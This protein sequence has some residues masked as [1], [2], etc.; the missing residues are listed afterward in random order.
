MILLVDDD[1]GFLDTAKKALKNHYKD[2]L[3]AGNAT[4]ALGL[5]KAIS[6]S[7]ALVDLDLPDCNGFDLISQIREARP[8]MPIVAMSGVFSQTVLESAKE[9]G[10]V[11]ILSKPPTEEWV[12]VVDRLRGANT[13]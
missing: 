1:A 2:I 8:G 3:L 6:F 4:D 10:A 5:L 7:V 13:D 12:R 9:F 11:E